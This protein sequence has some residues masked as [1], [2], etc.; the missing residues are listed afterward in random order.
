MEKTIKLMAATITVLCLTVVSVN[1]RTT[2]T[3]TFIGV[4]NIMM[5]DKS[6][7]MQSVDKTNGSNKFMKIRFS[8]YVEHKV[9]RY[10]C[11]VEKI[12]PTVLSCVFLEDKNSYGKSNDILS[13]FIKPD[14]TI[15]TN[16]DVAKEFISL[17]SKRDARC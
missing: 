10:S 8:N 12:K 15:E 1:A 13:Q 14:V 11:S 9:N 17:R 3:T 2:D 6:D 4:Q 16:V 7:D 5:T